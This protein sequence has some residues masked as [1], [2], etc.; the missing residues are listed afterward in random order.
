ML[1]TL[2]IIHLACIVNLIAIR[3]TVDLTILAGQMG[4][5]FSSNAILGLSSIRCIIMVLSTLVLEVTCLTVLLLVLNL[6][7]HVSFG[8]VVTHHISSCINQFTFSL[9]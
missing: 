8:H 4:L 1:I 9:M 2:F 3:N 6:P 5:L 7:C